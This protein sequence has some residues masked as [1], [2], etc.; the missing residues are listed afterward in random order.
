MARKASSATGTG[1]LCVLEPRYP[2]QALTQFFLSYTVTLI[3]TVYPIEGEKVKHTIK[4][5]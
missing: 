5:I 4:A 3:D 2:Q 1:T